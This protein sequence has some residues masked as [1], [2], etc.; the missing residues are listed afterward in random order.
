MVHPQKT[1]ENTWFTGKKLLAE[2][3]YVESIAAFNLLLNEK[4]IPLDSV[5]YCR[6]EANFHLE[7]YKECLRDAKKCLKLNTSFHAANFLSG[8]V[9]SKNN[10]FS[11]AIR[12]FTKA[13]LLDNKNPKYFYDRGVAYLSEEDLEDALKDFNAAIALKPD[14]AHAFYC[15]AYTLDLSG[16]INPAIIDLITAVEID[17]AYKDAYLELA[18]LYQRNNESAKACETINKAIKNGCALPEETKTNFCP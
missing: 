14:Y 15:R 2:K 11:G 1:D 13:I 5:F 9:K 17:P 18:S 8:L 6:A 12:S 3:K 16:K 4:T 7:R 10:N